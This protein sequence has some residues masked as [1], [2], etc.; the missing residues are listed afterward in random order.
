MSRRQSNRLAEILSL[1]T[2]PALLIS[3]TVVTVVAHFTKDS[4]DFWQESLV[5]IALLV[6]PGLLYSIRV[7]QKE[8]YIDLD[9]TERHDRIV[10]LMLSCLGAIIGA[11]LVTKYFHNQ[12]FV[13]MSFILVSM[14]IALTV[15]T[16]VWKISL[17][18]ATLAALVTLLAIFRGEVFAVG[19]ILLVPIFWARLK[20]KQHTPN[21]LIG[22]A[23]LGAVL[24]FVAAWFFRR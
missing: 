18:A 14:L 11:F 1:L 6:V 3:I 8:G 22:G 23:L 17:H 12:T 15:I 16:T 24:T 13:E 5:G 21:Q 2:N 7:W 4:A 10:P 9:L 19:Y 20:L